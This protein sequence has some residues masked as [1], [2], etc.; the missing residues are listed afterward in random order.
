MSPPLRTRFWPLLSLPLLGLLVC[1]AACAPN[2]PSGEATT[3]PGGDYLFCFW[4]TENFFDDEVNGWKT[5]PDK[6]FDQWFA[7][8]PAVLKEKLDHLSGA[9]IKMNGGKGPD[10]LA[11]AEVESERAAELLRGALNDKLRDPALHYKNVLFKDPHGGRHIATAI[12]TRLE[13]RKDKTQLHGKRMRILEG[14]VVAHGQDLVVLA[15]HWTSRVSDHEGEGR[16]RYGDACYG[17]FR[18]MHKANPEVAFLVCGD[19]NDPPNDESVTGHLHAIGDEKQVRAGGPE[20]YLLNLFAAYTDGKM[21]SH[22]YRGKW[23]CFDQIAVSPGLLGGQG[24]RCE[25]GSARIVN[26]LTADRRG[27]PWRFGSE[28]DRG[29]RGYSDHFPVTVRLTVK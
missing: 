12:L 16:D 2:V 1:L 25:V 27:H 28:R 26:D 20:P 23:L 19:F 22:N 9:L 7:N 11:L 21:G 6:D 15:T 14:H 10:I 18:A 8:T 3:A 29:E 24:W 17:V 13:V 5:E 4:N